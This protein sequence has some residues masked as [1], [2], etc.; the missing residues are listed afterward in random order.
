MGRENRPS[1]RKHRVTLSSK[2]KAYL[3]WLLDKINDVFV[4]GYALL[5]GDKWLAALNGTATTPNVAAIVV[6]SA[7]LGLAWFVI[8][9][10]KG[11]LE[12]DYE[13]K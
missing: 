13:S 1:R 2:T 6:L 11:E 9:L 5:T 8:G 12:K 4:A 3:N 10:F 7:F